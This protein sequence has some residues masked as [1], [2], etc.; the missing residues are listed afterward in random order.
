MSARY[1]RDV[2]LTHAAN[3]RGAKMLLWC[4]KIMSFFDT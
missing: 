1:I 2:Y 4:S 3:T